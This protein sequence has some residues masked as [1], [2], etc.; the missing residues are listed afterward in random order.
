MTKPNLTIK[1]IAKMCGV[2]ITT[3]SKVINK[4]FAGIGAATIAKVEAVVKKHGYRPNAVARSMITRKTHTIGLVLPDVRN[5]F[6][7]ELARGVEDVCNDRS[8]G[9]F[10]CNTDGRI[11]KE[12]ACIALLRGQVADGILF[13]TQNRIE[14]NPAFL[15][16]REDKYPFCLIE[17]YLKEMPDVPGVYFDNIGGAH[18]ATRYLLERGHRKIAFISGPE[19]TVNADYRRQGY[20]QALREAGLEPEAVLMT[21]GDYRYHS[22]YEAMAALL[23]RPSARFTALFASNDLMALGAFQ[24]LEEAGMGVPDDVSIISFDNAPFPNVMKPAITTI[25]LPA[26][27][28]GKRAAEML[29]DCLDGK[30]G[31]GARY[32]FAPRIIEKDSVRVLS[33]IP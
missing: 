1:D 14:F 21:T 5:P 18:M 25:E 20:E 2:S 3:V 33:E 11:E 26:Y 7:A 16:L 4:K 31:N 23:A 6:F 8:F 30:A 19:T 27:A 24:R 32:V 17:R 29:F 10:L 9:C 13:T 12:D 28:M 22:G 15:Q